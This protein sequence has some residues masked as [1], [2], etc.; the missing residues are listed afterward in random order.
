MDDAPP[1]G[2]SIQARPQPVLQALEGVDKDQAIAFGQRLAPGFEL[3]EHFAPEHATFDRTE[4]WRVQTESGEELDV[5]LASVPRGVVFRAG[6]TTLVG[7]I[8]DARMTHSIADLSLLPD[9]AAGEPAGTLLSRFGRRTVRVRTA[10]RAAI[11]VAP[12]PG[13]PFTGDIAPGSVAFALWKGRWWPAQILSKS[14][15][16]YRVHYDGWESNWDEYVSTDRLCQPPPPIEAKVGD[17]VSVEYRGAWYAA[18]VLAVHE[19]G[20]VRV[21][22]EG[23]DASWDEDVVPARVK[24]ATTTGSEDSALPGRPL[25][26]REVVAGETVFIAYDGAWYEGSVLEVRDGGYLIHYD[27]WDSSWDEVVDETRLRLR[28]VP[29]VN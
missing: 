22:Y 1:K 18:R 7:E 13:P 25:G 17:D 8:F 26:A 24:K 4:R 2:L 11:P 29:V 21:T 10:E 3:A 12:P 19:D 16:L 14:G 6:T 5:W 15:E 28:E 20:R 27:G 23:W 9:A